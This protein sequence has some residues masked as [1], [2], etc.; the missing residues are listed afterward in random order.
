MHYSSQYY[1]NNKIQLLPINMHWFGNCC[2]ILPFE[3]HGKQQQFGFIH[4]TQNP[5]LLRKC[6]T[7][8]KTSQTFICC[9]QTQRRGE[10]TETCTFDAFPSTQYATTCIFPIV[11]C[12]FP[13]S[14]EG[15][16]PPMLAAA[17]AKMNIKSMVYKTAFNP[18]RGEETISR[19]RYYIT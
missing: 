4:S 3:L 5:P 6:Y 9:I 7:T 16:H 17:S 12:C 13:L 1:L 15:Q 18:S 8:T 19:F 2:K 11:L 14:N 10:E